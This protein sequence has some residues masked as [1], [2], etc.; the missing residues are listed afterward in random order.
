[1]RH[2]LLKFSFTVLANEPFIFE[3]IF[4]FGEISTEV[5]SD[6]SVK[7]KLVYLLY[8]VFTS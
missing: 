2:M 4:L 1:M 7:Y 6:T 3:K 8:L 5:L